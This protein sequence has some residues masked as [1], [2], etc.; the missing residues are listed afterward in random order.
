MC[1]QQME[2]MDATARAAWLALGGGGGQV[3]DR[4]SLPPEWIA[5]GRVERGRPHGL[6]SAVSARG[7]PLVRCRTPPKPVACPTVC[8]SEGYL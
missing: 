4:S 3:V 1:T 5:S 6:V 2:Q 8:S 7:R